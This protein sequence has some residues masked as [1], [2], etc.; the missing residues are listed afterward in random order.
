MAKG[1]DNTG[2]IVLALGAG[3]AYYAYSQ[4]WLSSLFGSP[5]VPI[6]T[7]ATVTP[8]ATTTATPT[9]L[10]NAAIAPVGWFTQ[11]GQQTNLPTAPTGSKPIPSGVVAPGPLAQAIAQSMA[12]QGAT[13]A[14]INAAIQQ[15]YNATSG[16]PVNAGIGRFT[17]RTPRRTVVVFPRRHAAIVLPRNYQLRRRA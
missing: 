16:L 7:P 14:Q 8:A 12:N 10:P 6:A 15:E 17:I 13:A 9:A 5:T 4:G 1:S 2:L 3:A 11:G